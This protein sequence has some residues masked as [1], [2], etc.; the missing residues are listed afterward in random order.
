MSLLPHDLFPSLFLLTNLLIHLSIHI[1]TQR[2]FFAHRREGSP[3]MYV[4]KLD[5]RNGAE[6]V[7]VR[8]CEISI[9][10]SSLAGDGVWVMRFLLFLSFLLL[11]LLAALGVA[12]DG[13]RSGV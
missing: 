3:R 5:G 1:N 6:C 8:W 4:C 10:T 13:L 2:F 12:F 11:L 7:H 9:S